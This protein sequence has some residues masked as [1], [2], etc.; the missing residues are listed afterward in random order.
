MAGLNLVVRLHVHWV[1]PAVVVSQRKS[2]VLCENRFVATYEYSGYSFNEGDDSEGQKLTQV[3][4]NV[5]VVGCC[6]WLNLTVYG[7]SDEEEVNVDGST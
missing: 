6:S 2:T 7:S 1:I 4:A 5:D 3:G